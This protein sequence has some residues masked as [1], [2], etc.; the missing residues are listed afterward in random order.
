MHPGLADVFYA[1]SAGHSAKRLVGRKGG[2]MTETAGDAPPRTGADRPM[3]GVYEI[4]LVDGGSLWAHARDSTPRTELETVHTRLASEPFVR[5]GDTV[6]R[7]GDVRS[8]Q[9]HEEDGSGDGMFESLKRRFGGGS[10]TTYDD[11]G[12]TQTRPAARARRHD[13]EPGFTDRYVGYGGR[14]WSETKPFFLTSEF[15]TLIA[16]IAA[17]AIGMGASD[18]LDA[19]RGFTLI[20]ALAAAYMLSRGL[21]KSGTRDPN[22][23]RGPRY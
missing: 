4:R 13:D 17:V 15:L 12:A 14:P 1:V 20:A 9:L 6:V 19:T 23:D 8:I 21:A 3:G 2:V 11:D 16:T 7:S 18:E 22:P 10:M 5:V